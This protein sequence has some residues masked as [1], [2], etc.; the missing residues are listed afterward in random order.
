MTNAEASLNTK[1]A[2]ADALKQLMHHISDI[3]CALSIQRDL[4]VF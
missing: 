1:K 4:P 2:L 3:F